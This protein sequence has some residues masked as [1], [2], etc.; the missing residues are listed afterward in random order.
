MR[1][2]NGRQA[3]P[4]LPAAGREI[5]GQG[6]TQAAGGAATALG[7]TIVKGEETHD[8]EH[9][10]S[11]SENAKNIHFECFKAICM[12]AV[13]NTHCKSGEKNRSKKF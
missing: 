7:R 8:E 12:L 9:Q 5:Q 1:A 6:R 11:N 3:V 13:I 4:E 2:S 10:S